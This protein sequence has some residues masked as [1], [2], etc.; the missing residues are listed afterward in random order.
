MVKR[1]KERQ[2]K[3]KGKERGELP[4]QPVE[5]MVILVGKF[6]QLLLPNILELVH[7]QFILEFFFQSRLL[8]IQSRGS[9]TI[10][11]IIR[12]TAFRFCGKDNLI[13]THLHT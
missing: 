5:S 13:I 9:S 11:R 3:E 12:A 6:M 4:Q 2:E 7:L 8:S 10:R 1:E